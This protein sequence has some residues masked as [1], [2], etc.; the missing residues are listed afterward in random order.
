MNDTQSY[1]P[2]SH[3]H[4][5]SPKNDAPGGAFARARTQ[6]VESLRRHVA[7]R[8]LWQRLATAL[9]G[10]AASVPIGEIPNLPTR[11]IHYVKRE[12]IGTVGALLAVPYDTLRG[13]RNV[14]RVTVARTVASLNAWAPPAA[15][16]APAPEVVEMEV[17][18]SPP[19]W[20]ALGLGALM[21][22]MLARLSPR[23]RGVLDQ[24]MGVS[25]PRIVQDE[26]GR[27]L[28]VTESR[29]SQ[30]LRESAH[31]MALER[32]GVAL[33]AE[34]LDAA[35]EG[36]ALTVDALIERDP[37]FEAIRARRV[38]FE[39]L[40]TV[41]PGRRARFVRF[42]DARLLATF[43]QQTLDDAQR[44]ASEE[45]ASLRAPVEDAHVDA[46]VARHTRALGAAIES[47]VRATLHARLRPP[48][49]AHL[50][51]LE[52]E[53]VLRASPAPVRV[54]SFTRGESGIKWPRTA[55]W[56]SADQVTLAERFEGFD[57]LARV[58]V[59]RC[60]AWMRAH[61][62]DRI[63]YCEEL[64]AALE[65]ITLPAWFHPIMLGAMAKWTGGLRRQ[66]QRC[67]MLPERSAAGTGHSRR[68]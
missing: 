49:Y 62:P 54:D 48:V 17:S 68:K 51:P 55:V 44:A 61:G 27:S 56:V 7:R 3:E 32:E 29:I 10:E 46:L 20:S 26:I 1:A 66:R 6:P 42:G 67:L 40:L 8:A 15:T 22:A 14:G 28:G 24:Y 33:I 23:R 60:A 45:F 25:G 35:L 43:T 38:L 59:S 11:M 41:L 30:I 36:G 37:W 58:A 64:L 39:L 16:E 12:G 18:A 63:W 2:A 53:A 21:E 50:S 65:G 4:A 9:R 47:E 57:D 34:R 19:D 52:I 31:T 5:E 13:S